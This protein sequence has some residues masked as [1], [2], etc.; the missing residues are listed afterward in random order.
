MDHLSR[1]GAADKDS[2]LGLK[3]IAIGGDN[4]ANGVKMDTLA[5][6]W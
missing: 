1:V 5:S 4:L 6:V 3:M 2:G